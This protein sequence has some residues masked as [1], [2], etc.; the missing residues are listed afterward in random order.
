M[1]GLEVFEG[2]EKVG[3]GLTVRFADYNWWWA[4]LEA[5][6]YSSSSKVLVSRHPDSC[7][8]EIASYYCPQCLK[9][10]MD[11]EVALYRKRCPKCYSC[12]RCSSVLVDIITADKTL[13]HCNYC[14]WETGNRKAAREDEITSDPSDMTASAAYKA[15]LDELGR[16]KTSG[17]PS[18]SES[19]D[20]KSLATSE[21]GVWTWRDA[22]S[23]YSSLGSGAKLR[24]TPVV[25]DTIDASSASPLLSDEGKCSGISLRSKRTI[26]CRKDV[27]DSKMSILL[28]PK[29]FALEGD[30]SLKLQRGKWS[31]KDSSAAYRVPN[32]KAVALTD[33]KLHFTVRNP[34]DE[35]IFLQF[36][37]E[38]SKD[39]V[40][41]ESELSSAIVRRKLMVGAY[42][43]TP[44]SSPTVHLDE[45]E[46]AL[47]A[48]DESD[49]DDA[50]G[51]SS[52]TPDDGSEWVI[53]KTKS[54]MAKVTTPTLLDHSSREVTRLIV[55]VSEKENF[56]VSQRYH[57]LVSSR[58]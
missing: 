32:V 45:G 15:L 48:A 58:T 34:T 27:E 12:P 20:A 44:T 16:K 14:C 22:D 30:S 37:S 4:P 46:D 10:Y 31:V 43:T 17:G 33:G 47:L 2:G 18:S 52:S 28:Q 8:E 53:K 26:R 54:S 13:L 24:T 6:F 36:L 55:M 1:A 41:L 19:A 38:D 56:E 50:K 35:P 29:N 51:P 42:S 49:D 23:M 5:L 3:K 7:I 11:D 39:A 9:R 40:A 57:F 25:A 21:K